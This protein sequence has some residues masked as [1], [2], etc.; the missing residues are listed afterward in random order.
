M[1]DTETKVQFSFLFLVA[2]LC[3]RALSTET[4]QTRTLHT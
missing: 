1:I 3:S 2:S 4:T